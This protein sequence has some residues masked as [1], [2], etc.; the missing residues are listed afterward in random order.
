MA[1]GWGSTTTL[2]RYTS[3]FPSKNKKK[4]EIE[5]YAVREDIVMNLE[6]LV[7]YF[8]AFYLLDP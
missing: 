4:K 2:I 5:Y 1:L 7:I 8:G 6:S 3:Q